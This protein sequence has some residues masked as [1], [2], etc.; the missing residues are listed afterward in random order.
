V[1]RAATAKEGFFAI[2]VNDV[3]TIGVIVGVELERGAPGWEMFAGR[4]GEYHGR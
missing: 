4:G 1:I 3:D 2:T